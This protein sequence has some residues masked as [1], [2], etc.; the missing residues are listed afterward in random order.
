MPLGLHSA[1]E[2]DWK[3]RPGS[4]PRSKP[5]GL[6]SGNQESEGAGL[7]GQHLP[8]ITVGGTLGASSAH[9]QA[10]PRPFSLAGVAPSSQSKPGT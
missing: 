3:G 10:L 9:R 6:L 1:G 7:A 8:T 4:R 2:T 5:A